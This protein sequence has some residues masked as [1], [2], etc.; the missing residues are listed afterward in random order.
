MTD[1]RPGAV[2]AAF[3]LLMVGAVLLMVGGLMAATVSFDAL[4]EAAGPTVSEESVRAYARMYRGAG[5]LAFAA[6][7]GLAVMA[8]R[9][10]NRD[11]RSRRAA[12]ALGLAI[13]VVVAIAAV[14]A[15]TYILVL[16]S[17]I[18][19]IAGTLLLSRPGVVEWYAGG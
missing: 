15:G 3:W 5:G 2:T 4:R 18:P 12:M 9:T 11:P 1:I 17:L 19:I 13:V 10:R 16:L 8:A 6:G 14:F 7:L